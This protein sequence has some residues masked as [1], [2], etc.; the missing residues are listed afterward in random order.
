VRITDAFVVD[1][2][3]NPRPRIE[4]ADLPMTIIIDNQYQGRT[5]PI[6]YLRLYVAPFFTQINV[7]FAAIFGFAVLGYLLIRFVANRWSPPELP[8]AVGQTWAAWLLIAVPPIGFV[9]VYGWIVVYQVL[10]LIVAAGAV[11]AVFWGLRWFYNRLNTM[12][13]PLIGGALTGL[14]GVALAA[15]YVDRVRLAQQVPQWFLDWV[16]EGQT[17]S[18][19]ADATTLWGMLSSAVVALAAA[20]VVAVVV[21]GIAWALQKFFDGGRILDTVRIPQAAWWVLG[22]PILLAFAYVV[23]VG[24]YGLVN[25]GVG[26]VNFVGGQLIPSYGE[27]YFDQPLSPL[28][29]PALPDAPPLPNF[30]AASPTFDQQL[31][32]WVRTLGTAELGKLLMVLLPLALTGLIAWVAYRNLRSVA[33]GRAENLGLSTVNVFGMSV[34]AALG[35]ALAYFIFTIVQGPALA[36]ITD[37][38]LSKGLS[39]FMPDTDT[40]RWGGLLLTILL[41]AAGIVLS[42]PFGVLLALGRRSQQPIISLLC[43]LYIEA[44]RGVPFITVL[45]MAQLLVPLASPELAEIPNVFRA[46][47][48]TIMFAAAYL[49]ENVRGGLQAISR[50][51]DEAAKALGLSGAQTTAFIILP[52]AL[53]IV[54]PTLVGQCIAL[55]K[56]T[57]LVAIVG[58]KDLLGI[59]QAVVAQTEFIGRRSETFLFMVLIYVVVCFGMGYISRQIEQT[60]SGAARRQQI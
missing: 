27:L 16:A 9:L 36:L 5:A 53:R 23:F 43:T 13:H 3:N 14:L 54:I 45:F 59:A 4:G 22:A 17:R 10:A 25:A 19:I 15:V 6:D 40:R 28:M 55:F 60:G 11:V 49:A 38:P 44:V 7:G 50:G 20:L 35:L 42:F 34:L 29:L 1:G 8:R 51:Q 47:V 52:Q 31:S 56:D 21:Y 37:N 12:V 33:D 2:Q 46:V 39:S 18:E 41:S 58:L 32:Q 48:G 24:V 30:A 26:M 57:T